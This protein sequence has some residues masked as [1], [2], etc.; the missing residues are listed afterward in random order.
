MGRDARATWAKRVERWSASG[1]SAIEFAAEIGVNARTLTYWKWKLGR[2]ESRRAEFVEV[3]PT[4]EVAP[5]GAPSEHLEVVLDGGVV[6]RVP[7]RFDADALRRVV[8]ALG[9]A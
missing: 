4:S 9:G 3:V 6:I 1:L 7:A 8:A 2:T 5:S